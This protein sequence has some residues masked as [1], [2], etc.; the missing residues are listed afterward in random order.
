MTRLFV[1]V[2]AKGNGPEEQWC[3]TASWAMCGIVRLCASRM[4][5]RLSPG[6]NLCVAKKSEA[7]AGQLEL[8]SVSD[9]TFDF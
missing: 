6:K 2:K 3:R 8:R 1:R 5:L 4:N 7:L 9:M